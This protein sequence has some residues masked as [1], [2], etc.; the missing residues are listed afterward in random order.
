[1][2]SQEI[3]ESTL[4]YLT[5]KPSD[6]IPSQ[7][8]EVVSSS[9]LG[10][11]GVSLDLFKEN[12]ESE[13]HKKGE[14]QSSVLYDVS[15]GFQNGIWITISIEDVWKSVY[16]PNDKD[17]Y[18]TTLLNREIK[19]VVTEENNVPK[20]IDLRSVSTMIYDYAPIHERVYDKFNSNNWKY[21][22]KWEGLKSFSEQ[23]HQDW[24]KFR[25]KKTN[26]S[27]SLPTFVRFQNEM[28]K[29]LTKYLQEKKSVEF[30][31]SFVEQQLDTAHVYGVNH[32]YSKE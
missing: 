6:L 8:E 27:A 11:E 1:M 20:Q 28:K 26:V 25:Q 10:N 3:S 23:S 14:A 18:T 7:K 31:T 9:S 16:N 19:S 32:P 5:G 4:N 15:Y 12:L 21:V 30:I 17:P 13:A 22:F 29:Q 24:A 2:T